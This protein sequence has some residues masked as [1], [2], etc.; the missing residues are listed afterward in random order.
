MHI[1]DNSMNASFNSMH[2]QFNA[3]FNSMHIFSS[4]HIQF[5]ASFNSMPHL[6]QCIFNSMLHSIQ[7][8]FNS[9]LHSIQCIFNSMLHS[10]IQCS[11][12]FNGWPGLSLQNKSQRIWERECTGCWMPYWNRKVLWFPLRPNLRFLHGKSTLLFPTQNLE[13]SVGLLNWM[14]H[15]LIPSSL[16]FSIQSNYFPQYFPI[17]IWRRTS[18]T[19]SFPDSLRFVLEREIWSSIELN[20]ALNWMKHWIEYALNWMKHW[21]EYALNWMEHWIEWSIE[22]NMHWTEY[23]FEWSIELNICIIGLNE[24]FNWNALNWM[25][26]SLKLSEICIELSLKQRLNG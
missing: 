4:M 17:S 18:F 16:R 1:S 14:T 8:I 12:Q 6:I 2:I 9:M 26:H 23:A 11:I 22:L 10:N 7:R 5:N 13:T 3:S 24:T 19:F 25:K 15:Y 20:G 21:I